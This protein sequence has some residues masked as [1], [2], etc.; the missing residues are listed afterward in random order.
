[1]ILLSFSLTYSHG[2]NKIQTTAL[3]SVHYHIRKKKKK[4]VAKNKRNDEKQIHI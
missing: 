3:I 2:L 1:M 4:K